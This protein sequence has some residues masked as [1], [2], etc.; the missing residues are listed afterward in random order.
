M[1]TIF[2]DFNALTESEHVCLTVRGSEEDIRNQGVRTGDWVWLSDGE[3]QVGARVAEDPRYR[4]VGIPAWETL[5]QLDEPRDF[6]RIWSD[7][8]QVLQS[9]DQSAEKEV[10]LLQLLALFETAAPPG[11]RDAL[12]KGYIAFK[13]AGALY[14]LGLLELALV[15][16]EEARRDRPDHPPHYDFFYLEILRRTDLDRAL[17]EAEDRSEKHETHAKV[18]AACINIAA[19]QADQLSDADFEPCGRRI[20]EW[21]DRFE[22]APGREE[23][24]ASVLAQVQFNHGLVLLRLGST[25][26]AKRQL[27]IAHRANPSDPSLREALRLDSYDQKA[28][29]IAS[30]FR[31]RV[32]PLAA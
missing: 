29:Q 10:R 31:A 2:A 8:Q 14:S 13:R 18:L 6:A 16:I 19:T 11:V 1:K 22:H 30:Q 4:L 3:I 12:P 23:V 9:P 25:A 15:E 5:I 17:R 20:L 24:R 26:E 7:L 27:E 32:I 21:V 28:Q